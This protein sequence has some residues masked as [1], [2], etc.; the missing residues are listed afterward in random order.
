M[1]WEEKDDTELQECIDRLRK[2]Q[3]EL[4]SQINPI[5]VIIN[6]T[7]RIQS[8]KRTSYSDKREMITTIITPKDQ[9]G[10]DMTDEY[11][12]KIKEEC[13]EKTNELLGE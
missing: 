1:P 3:Q 7:I 8:R 11:R 10:D 4:E 2:R 6:N 13:M 5:K 9:W 12:L